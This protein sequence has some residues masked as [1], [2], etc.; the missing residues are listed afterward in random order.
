MFI[1]RV[2]RGDT[3]FKIARKYGV[4]AAKIIENNL[5]SEPDRLCVGQELI[6]LT[7]SRSY[8]TRGGDT[9]E[10]I[11]KRFSVT[12]RQIYKN[13]PHLTGLDRILPTKEI[14]VKYPFE[15]N[16]CA[17]ALGVYREGTEN[18][19]L[20][21]TLPYISYIA[22][23]GGA[24][25]GGNIVS[26][27]DQGCVIE[28]AK[29]HGVIPIL[30]LD[31]K[32]RL[33][34]DALDALRLFAQ[35]SGYRA[36]MLN[37]DENAPIDVIFELRKKLLE[38]DM[39]LF[40]AINCKEQFAYNDICDC[41]VLSFEKLNDNKI[42]S[43]DEGERS[44]FLNYAKGYDSPRTLI[45]LSSYAY[46]END[47]ITKSDFLSFARRTHSEIVHDERALTNSFEFNRYLRGKRIK[48]IARELSLENIKAR[49]DLIEE[50]GFMGICIDIKNACLAHLM[51]FNVCFEST[52]Y[53]TL[54]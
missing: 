12:E 22:I 15:K 42:A 37:A 16:S 44:Y 11:A 51:M 52:H 32:E 35:K 17:L 20:L 14:A 39:A 34:K 33:T 30:K 21:T 40:L 26:Y 41:C 9:V 47:S 54:G 13:N 3:I 5:L 27:F 6:I 4:P 49:L 23:H 43:F 48:G 25:S 8:M 2:E 18:E 50:L 1:H 36:I 45:D 53:G 10:K 29:A 19:K 7:P 31:T 24:I 28:Q 46:I 38:Y